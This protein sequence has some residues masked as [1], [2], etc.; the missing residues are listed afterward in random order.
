MT[1]F[2]E[3]DLDSLTDEELSEVEKKYYSFLDGICGEEAVNDYCEFH[4]D[5]DFCREIVRYIEGGSNLTEEELRVM[6]YAY[7]ND[8]DR[9]SELL[10][11]NAK[12]NININFMAAE[13]PVALVS[14]LESGNIEG[15]EI[16]LEH[17]ASPDIFASKDESLLM[18]MVRKQAQGSFVSYYEAIDLLL[19]HG[20]DPYI[21]NG[22]GKICADFARKDPKLV[23]IFARHGIDFLDTQEEVC[24]MTKDGV[25][26]YDTYD[27]CGRTLLMNY[28][29]S[30]V[31]KRENPFHI[32]DD[33]WSGIKRLVEKAGVNINTVSDDCEEMTALMYT[34]STWNDN[35]S[36]E[37]ASYLLEHGADPNI[38]NAHRERFIDA[39][40]MGSF[41]EARLEVLKLAVKHGADIN[42]H[43]FQGMT[44]LMSCIVSAR[45]K[46]DDRNFE[47]IKL[48]VESGADVNAR[49]DNENRFTV[50]MYAAMG[51]CEYAG[52]IIEYLVENGADTQ[53]TI[54][55]GWKA[56]N[57][58]KIRSNPSKERV[59]SLLQ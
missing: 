59:R 27:D 2:D 41:D 12:V 16:L 34:F 35:F 54:K 47:A 30:A 32:H 25:N 14:A 5:W 7:V 1:I 39:L 19:S 33:Y 29:I 40:C 48:L 17:G 24:F 21:P 31:E 50:L 52:D 57:F 15:M 44:P 20:A 8:N 10:D 18:G 26:V 28:V 4:S 55:N 49:R 11:S 42:S 23:E 36:P 43:D 53:I 37:I 46:E 45:R 58:L 38:R 51:R 22:S 56:V 13:G 3:L 6:I 9:L